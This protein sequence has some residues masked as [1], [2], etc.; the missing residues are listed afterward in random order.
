MTPEQKKELERTELAVMQVMIETGEWLSAKHVKHQATAVHIQER[1]GRVQ[2][3]DFVAVTRDHDRV[4]ADLK[5]WKPVFSAELGYWVFYSELWKHQEY[6][7]RTTLGEQFFYLF[8]VHD[9]SF[10][11]GPGLYIANIAHLYYPDHTSKGPIQGQ[12]HTD[13]KEFGVW[14]GDRFRKVCD[15]ALYRKIRYSPED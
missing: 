12:A 11:R 15:I 6:I 3:C 2:P 4:R 10:P 8:L 1:L 5:L 7:R 13:G 9:K 14:S